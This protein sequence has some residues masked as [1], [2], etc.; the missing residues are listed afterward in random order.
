MQETEGRL[1]HGGVIVRCRLGEDVNRPIRSNNRRLRDFP[2]RAR[3]RESLLTLTTSL[4]SLFSLLLALLLLLSPLLLLLPLVE[5]L[6]EE[7]SQV[8]LR[9]I[10]I[11]CIVSSS[12]AVSGREVGRKSGKRPRLNAKGQR[13]AKSYVWTERIRRNGGYYAE[14]VDYRKK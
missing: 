12:L 11:R 13:Q 5:G 14:V 7:D 4:G 9:K 8:L 6:E 3:F 2:S 1:P 10:R